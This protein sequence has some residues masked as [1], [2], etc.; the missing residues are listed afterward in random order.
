M[1]KRIIVTGAEGFIGKHLA[2][3]LEFPVRCDITE[4]FGVW[5]PSD[6]DL[7]FKNMN[8]VYHLG[9]ISSTTE[10]D[11]N[12]ITENNIKFSCML[13][14]EC[15]KRDVPF[16]YASSAS[17]YGLGTNGF[18]EDIPLTPLNYYAISKA[19]FDNFVNLKIQ[20]NPTA[21]IIGLR[22]FN[23]Y[24]SGE[25][26]KGDM[27]SPVHKF[28]K[29]SKEESEIRIFQGSE[30]YMRD[31]IH[32]NDVVDI[33]KNAPQLPS[34]IYNVGTGTPRSFLDVAQIVSNLSGAAIKEI[35]FP[36]HLEGKYQDFTCSDNEKINK[37]GTTGK[38]TSLEDGINEVY[39]FTSL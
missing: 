15:I 24:G 6:I 1:S 9:A 23:V 36:K 18:R 13:L 22:Y 5:P 3:S 28:I 32:V 35:P 11:L 37:F 30:N 4:G 14:E 25:E 38:R 16:V 39:T 29:Q 20:D 26:H 34:G 2:R 27:S 7:H 17:V 8:C 19:S 21:K 31:F 33:T 12:L 10:T